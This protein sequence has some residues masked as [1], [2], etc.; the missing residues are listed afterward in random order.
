MFTRTFNFLQVSSASSD[1]SLR[2]KIAGVLTTAA[3]KTKDPRLSAL[4]VSAT[5][6][7]FDKVKETIQTMVENLEK[8]QQD[9]VKH[10]D[11]CIAELTQNEDDTTSKN[12]DKDDLDAKLEDLTMTI[13][14]L[15]KEIDGLKAA[16]AE[17]SLQLKLAGENREKANTEFQAVVAD[18]RA[19]QALLKKALDILKDFYDKA[20]LVQTGKRVVQPAGPPPPAGFKSYKKSEASGGV[21]GMMQQIIDDAASLEAE[22]TRAETDA[23]SE[24]E[25]FVNDT[26]EELDTL[27]ANLVNKN[28]IK[29]QTEA[30]KVEA[31]KE[32]ASV[33]GDLE[34]LANANHDLHVSCDYTLKNFD[35]R[36]ATRLDEIEALKQ[37]IAIFS[38]ASFGAF[39]QT[40]R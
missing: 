17:A 19:T 29:G 9:E 35:A 20:A 36:Q 15:T 39:M 33:V 40:L 27:N 11:F 18:Q 21:M 38:G 24:Y 32:H 8:E 13:A 2:R 31:E 7:S 12:R 1:L 25:T 28:E 5:T 30:A 37:S 23:Q 3:K 6:K 16:I 14:E 26:N 4:A 22:A 34:S 10:R